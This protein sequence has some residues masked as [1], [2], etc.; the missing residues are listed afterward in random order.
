VTE[1]IDGAADGA[2]ADV[3]ED[4]ALVGP[5]EPCLEVGFMGVDEATEG[6]LGSLLVGEARRMAGWAPSEEEGGA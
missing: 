5:G 6:L 1:G 2:V 4:D 3:T